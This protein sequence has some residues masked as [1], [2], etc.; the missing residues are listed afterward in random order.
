MATSEPYNASDAVELLLAEVLEH[1]E[2]K[3]TW[4]VLGEPTAGKTEVLDGLYQRLAE[5]EDVTPILLSP[6]PRAYD[7]AHVALVELAEAAR[8]NRSNLEV[9]R[10]PSKSWRT[11]TKRVETWL[12]RESR[13]VLLADEPSSWSPGDTYFRTFIQ[14]IWAMVLDGHGTATVTAGP[15]PFRV[16]HHHPLRLHP[17]SD[18]EGVLRAID[19]S[20]LAAARDS[21]AARFNDAL[22]NTSRLQVR[23]LVAIAAL[24]E[25]ALERIDPKLIEHRA[26]LVGTLLRLVD[27]HADA[28]PLRDVWLHLAAVREPFDDALLSRVGGDHLSAIGQAVLHQC[29]LFRR[30]DHLVLHESLRRIPSMTERQPPGLHSLLADYY[31]ERFNAAGGASRGRLRDAIEAFHHASCAGIVALETFRPFFVDQL[32]ILG[33]HLSFERQQWQRAAEVFGVALQWEPRNAYAAH[34]RAFNLDRTVSEPGAVVDPEEVERL[35]RQAIEEAPEHAWFRSRLITFLIAEARIDEAWSEWLQ[36][37]E[38]IEPD[39]NEQLYYGL[40]LH[41]AR[42]FLYRGELEHTDAV[43]RGVPAAIRSDERFM[44][45]QQRLETLREARDAGSYVPAPYLR[46]RW[47]DQPKI[48]PDAERLTRWLA[49]RVSEVD[50]DVIEVDVADI[51]PRKEPIYGRLELPM[52]SLVR[53]WR[54]PGDARELQPGTFIEIGFYGAGDEPLGVAVGHPRLRWPD[55]TRPQEDP[56]RYL[57]TAA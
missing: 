6:P 38:E 33:Y 42:S 56:D 57:R 52:D 27:S 2:A 12:E 30:R 51:V 48:L 31:R 13:V 1:R 41:V 23:L 8:Q 7:A 14:D 4:S 24:D 37:V 32:N 49:G 17:A 43:L 10:D 3:H 9:I 47:W 25:S 34:Y 18:P 15:T 46:P 29:L 11:K 53:W 39:L 20:V 35:Y 26:E 36:A 16:P 40:H 45:I 54:G 44:A 21:V 55:L 50:G 19:A 28:R 5:E 22:A